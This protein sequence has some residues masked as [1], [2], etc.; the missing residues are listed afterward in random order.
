M[1]TQAEGLDSLADPGVPLAVVKTDHC[2]TIVHSNEVA[3]GLLQ[4]EDRGDQGVSLTDLIA[5]DDPGFLES[6]LAQVQAQG[7]ALAQEVACVDTDGRPFLVDLQV[8]HEQGGG[9]RF[10]FRITE[11]LG[12]RPGGSGTD[13]LLRHFYDLHV[14]GM[15]I[16]SPHKRRWLRVNDR[17]CEIL[18]YF[19]EKLSG[20]T[21]DDVIDPQERFQDQ[22]RFAQI[23]AGGCETYT[24]ATRFLH[25]DGHVIHG[26]VE[27]RGVRDGVGAL[28]CCLV[29][30]QDR[31]QV[32][33][34]IHEARQ[35]HRLQTMR[36]HINQAIV[37][38]RGLKPLLQD[39]CRIS[40]E[41]GGFSACWIGIWDQDDMRNLR[42]F[43]RFGDDVGDVDPSFSADEWQGEADPLVVNDLP[44]E[45]QLPG[46]RA[47][48]E[49]GRHALARFSIGQRGGLGRHGEP[50]C[51]PGRFLY[52]GHGI[53]PGGD[54]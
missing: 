44:Q 38:S 19:R 40:V 2:G 14:L 49:A 16:I 51:R 11:R 8:A 46:S 39:V 12:R 13:G 22:E 53:D 30:L 4:L 50:V 17:L 31:T 20:R 7:A 15:A 33:E 18:G 52:P 10:L 6:L 37:R 32:R 45:A 24:G 54:G 34:T 35:Q 41:D 36:V 26:N 48:L 5:P 28:Q 23:R 43:T 47:A 1:L 29:T 42:V 21:W 27:V 3:A 25:R 9:D